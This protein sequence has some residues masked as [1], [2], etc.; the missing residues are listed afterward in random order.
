LGIGSIICKFEKTKF[1]GFAEKKLQLLQLVMDADEE[2]TGKLFELVS[3]LQPSGNRFSD[4]ALKKFHASRQQYFENPE[5]GLTLEE[6][7]AQI[8]RLRKG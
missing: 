3:H 6:A 8:R 1:M 7:H 2:T 4:E 5:T